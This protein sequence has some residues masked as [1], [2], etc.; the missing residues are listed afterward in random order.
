MF[1]R[2]A[3]IFGCAAAAASLSA[4]VPVAGYHGLRLPVAFFAGNRERLLQ[5][6]RNLGPGT[7]AIIKSMPEQPRNGDAGQ[8]FRQDSDFYYLTGVEEP[9]AVALLSADGDKPYTLLV[10]SRDP[11][12]EA[13]NGP[14]LGVE[15][16]RNLGADQAFDFPKGDEV[17]L[18]AIKKAQRIVLV[19][20]LD[21]EFRTR[22]LDAALPLG[23]DNNHG[24]FKKSVV[25][26]RHLVAEMRSIKQPAELDMIQ[27]AV[28]VS[29]E[30]HLAA[31]RATRTA[32]NEGQVAGAFEGAV[33]GL[34]ARFLGYDTIAGAG[35]QSCI[36]HYPFNDA[37]LHQGELQLM[38]AGAEVG[39]YTADI[40]RT[41]PVNGKFSTDQRA[42][43]DL[44][45]RAQEAGIA[46]CVVG[47]PHI[48][49]HYAASRVVSDGLVDL[50]ILK[51]G[52]DE[53]Y[54]RGDWKRFFIH[55]TGHWLGLDVHDAGD[56]GPKDPIYRAGGRR[57]LEAGMVVTVEPGLYIPKGS[58]GVDP[59]WQGIGVRIEDDILVT[60]AGPKNLSARL[61]REAEDVERA[62]K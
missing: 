32:A 55:G 13:W 39:Y 49:A 19:C 6:L 34:G 45:L 42:L 11:K 58:E 25:D 47:S 61:P 52:K 17:L 33:R 28:E 50:G 14:R 35:N 43:Y 24:Q 57:P 30:G 9:G 16:A 54:Q 22:I 29:I 4:Q 46:A 10:R 60:K 1:R 59:R 41:W 15:G 53:V 31:M 62:L 23:T 5:H 27:K 21:R 36:L 2:T 48:A 38:D 8:P 44:V 3:L 37:P 26:G 40:T 51:G 20:N 7:L 18:E 12:R 56:Y